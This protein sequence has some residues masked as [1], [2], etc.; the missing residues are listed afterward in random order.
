[1]YLRYFFIFADSCWLGFSLVAEVNRGLKSLC[2]KVSN[3]T[4][5]SADI[6]KLKACEAKANTINYNGDECIVMTCEDDEL[7]IEPVDKGWFIYHTIP[8]KGKLSG[9]ISP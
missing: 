1:M 9:K 2:T 6:C 4:G 8:G 7:Q 5:I 3:Y